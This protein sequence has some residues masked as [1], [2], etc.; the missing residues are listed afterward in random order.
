MLERERHLAEADRFRAAAAMTVARAQCASAMAMQSPVVGQPFLN[1]GS[2][3]PRGVILQVVPNAAHPPSVVDFLY[4]RGRARNFEKSREPRY[5]DDA[6]NRLSAYGLPL[7]YGSE[8]DMLTTMPPPGFRFDRQSTTSGCQSTA[9]GSLTQTMASTVFQPIAAPFSAPAVSA[10]LPHG[11]LSPVVSVSRNQS[12]WADQRKVYGDE[13]PNNIAREVNNSS[14]NSNSDKHAFCIR[15]D[16]KIIAPIMQH[17]H[18]LPQHSTSL[19]PPPPPPSHA[20]L[21]SPPQLASH[22]VLPTS[23]GHSC[24]ANEKQMSVKL[25]KFSVDSL[26]AN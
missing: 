14:R 4:S 17:P 2:M 15:S 7:S 23:K 25:F 19:P 13:A 6:K 8:P 12:S 3:P 16:A 10:M 9:R 20:S 26:L 21:S 22:I 1:G 5:A 11:F 24:K 18:P